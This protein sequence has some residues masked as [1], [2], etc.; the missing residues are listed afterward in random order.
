MVAG[1]ASPSLHEMLNLSTA[2]FD[3]VQFALTDVVDADPSVRLT[4]PAG[5]AWIKEIIF[6]NTI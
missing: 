6:K 4:T 2:L 5:P 1:D 3:P